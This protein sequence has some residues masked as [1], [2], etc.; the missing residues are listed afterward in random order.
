VD[1]AV[2]VPEHLFMRVRLLVL[3][4]L[5]FVVACG[6]GDDGGVDPPGPGQVTVRYSPKPGEIVLAIPDSVVL[7]VSVTPE[8]PFGVQFLLGD[9]L[10]HNGPELKVMGDRVREER[11]R[12]IVQVGSDYY[13]D[14]WYV[15]VV[16]DIERPVPPPAAP[17]AG[18]GSEPGSVALRWDRPPDQLIDPEAPLEGFDIAWSRTSFAAEDFDAQSATF[19]KDNSLGIRQHA[20]V[21]GLLE[22]EDYY[23]RVRSVDVLGRTSWP[24]EEVFSV[25]TGSFELSGTVWQ[26]DATGWPAP[27]GSVLVEAGPAR[28]TTLE[29]GRF[30]LPNLPDL[31]RLILS[32]E[33]GS[34]LYTLPILTS[35]LETV[36]RAL[37]LVLVPRLTVDILDQGVVT[38]STLCEFLLQATYHKRDAPPYDFRP[39]PEYPVKVWVWDYS[40]PDS[41]KVDPGSDDV[42]YHE[43]FQTAIDRW[44]DGATGDQRLMEL[45]PVSPDFDPTGDPNSIGVMVQLYDYPPPW[46]NLGEVNFVRPLGGGVG[47]ADPQLLSVD[48]RPNFPTQ[49]LAERVIAHEL[50][51]TLG[52]VHTMSES[53]L[54][55]GTSDLAEGFPTPE[56]LFVA[57][58]IRHGGKDMQANWISKP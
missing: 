17:L 16:T 2:L 7:S 37:D 49:S 24:T 23:L 34:G 52:L 5:L 39:W 26:L 33:E 58:F 51:H 15:R 30:V 40:V 38:E 44:N 36:D 28:V 1:P 47:S 46:P 9:S 50:G 48:L 8:Q 22:K 27:V 56:E 31:E 57:R 19:V 54:M 29:D 4:L 18:P 6:G 41:I 10:V 55:H 43:A 53:N 21:L 3:L 35:P 12:A 11:Y 20:E 14:E 45:V 13:D 32:A 25:S 42:L